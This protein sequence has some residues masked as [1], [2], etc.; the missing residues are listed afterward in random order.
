[1]GL[2]ILG[3]SVKEIFFRCSLQVVSLKGEVEHDREVSLV[4]S[5]VCN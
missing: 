4:E 5:V 2:S 3:C 1:M